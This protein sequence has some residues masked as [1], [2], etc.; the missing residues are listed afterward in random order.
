V[1]FQTIEEENESGRVE[2]MTL[3]P[4][5]H[6]SNNRKLESTTRNIMELSEW[7][8]EGVSPKAMPGGPAE[9]LG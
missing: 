7:E 3:H 1:V 5:G 8:L 6:G 4:N 2:K 9:P